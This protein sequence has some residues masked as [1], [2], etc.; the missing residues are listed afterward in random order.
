MSDRVID[1]IS[2]WPGEKYKLRFLGSP[3]R[4]F[5]FYHEG[6]HL[7]VIDPKQGS[8]LIA[9]GFKG[10][11]EYWAVAIDRG[12]NGICIVEMTQELFSILV[13]CSQAVGGSLADIDG[14]DVEVEVT[15]MET[16]RYIVRLGEAT[17][18]SQ[19]VM[20]AV[21][22]TK[23]SIAAEILNEVSP[24]QVLG[25]GKEA[26]SLPAVR[27]PSII[28]FD[29]SDMVES[30]IGSEE[31]SRILL[32]FAT[33]VSESGDDKVSVSASNIIKAMR[34]QEQ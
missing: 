25:M 10:V 3:H 33:H 32:D 16:P 17:T 9:R 27:M 29:D 20:Q 15:G 6:G 34:K 12:A 18:V 22:D 14:A 8:V 13:S 1:L 23:K 31:W 7:D 21:T 28:D 30:E 5:R 26:F 19:E 24:E 4:R 11:R 2:A